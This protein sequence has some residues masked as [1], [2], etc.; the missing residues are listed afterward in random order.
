MLNKDLQDRYKDLFKKIDRMLEIRNLVSHSF[1]DDSG[2][3][4]YLKNTKNTH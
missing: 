4:V 2:Y 3:L 1:L